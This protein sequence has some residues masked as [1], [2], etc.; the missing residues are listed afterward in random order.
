M[1]PAPFQVR[2]LVLS[3]HYVALPGNSPPLET[4]T[5]LAS[6]DT[7]LSPSPFVLIPTFLPGLSWLSLFQPN[8]PMLVTQSSRDVPDLSRHHSLP[9][10]FKIPQSSFFNYIH[11]T[12]IFLTLKTS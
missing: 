2:Y 1:C 5:A 11:K 12:C 8:L 4:D 3:S 9:F 10:V 7:S 6:L